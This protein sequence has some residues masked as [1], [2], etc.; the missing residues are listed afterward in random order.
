[1]SRNREPSKIEQRIKALEEAS[2]YKKGESGFAADNLW[3]TSS[4]S[5]TDC[6][7]LPTEK[8]LKVTTNKSENETKQG[9]GKS[10]RV[11]RQ[12]PSPPTQDNQKSETEPKESTDVIQNREPSKIEKRIK[13]LKEAS[14]FKQGDSGFT[15]EKLGHRQKRGNH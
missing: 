3:K 8:S 5:A 14:T 6:T 2:A 4:E 12:A 13:S 1:L 11:K 15:K 9:Q 10:K 7:N